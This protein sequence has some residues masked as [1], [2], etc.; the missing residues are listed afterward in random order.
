M[1][2]NNARKGKTKHLRNVKDYA[3]CGFSSCPDPFLECQRFVNLAVHFIRA[4]SSLILLGIRLLLA[5]VTLQYFSKY[6]GNTEELNVRARMQF[7][8]PIVA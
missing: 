7:R 6:V 3:L 8:Y 5:M 2:A 4:R 1:N